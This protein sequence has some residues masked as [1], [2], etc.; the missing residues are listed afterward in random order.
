MASQLF[1]LFLL[2][3]N[4]PNFYLEMASIKFKT[5]KKQFLLTQ[6]IQK[7]WF[8]NTVISNSLVKKNPA[9]LIF[10]LALSVLILLKPCFILIIRYRGKNMQ[11]SQVVV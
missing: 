4:T 5:F 6:F 2:Q 9:M 10:F 1:L 7:T 11:S 8:S 3:Q